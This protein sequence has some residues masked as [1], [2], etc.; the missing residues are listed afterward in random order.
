MDSPQRYSDIE[1]LTGE[2]LGPS[3]RPAVE[4]DRLLKKEFHFFGSLYSVI[5][6]PCKTSQKGEE[7]D[8]VQVFAFDGRYLT[9][10]ALGPNPGLNRAGTHQLF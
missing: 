10:D 4:V 6:P 2:A 1:Y 7:E 5:R 9:R 8:E 3:D